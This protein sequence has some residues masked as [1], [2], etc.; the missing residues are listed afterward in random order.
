MAQFKITVMLLQGGTIAI[1]GLPIDEAKFKTDKKIVDEDLIKILNVENDLFRPLWIELNKRRIRKR[2]LRK[3][4]KK[5]CKK[6]LRMLPK[7]VAKLRRERIDY[8]KIE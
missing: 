1:T 3:P 7:K 5:L 4:P 2:K 6:L 8:L